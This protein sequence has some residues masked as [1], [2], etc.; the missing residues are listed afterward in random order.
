MADIET[1]DV[2]SDFIS[3][4]YT[5]IL[6]SS[7]SKENP[8]QYLETRLASLETYWN[9]F[10]KNH[11]E[12]AVNEDYYTTPY[13]KE[14]HFE[15]V[16]E[17]YTATKPAILQEIE[18]LRPSASKAYSSGEKNNYSTIGLDKRTEDNIVPDTPFKHLPAL[19][20]SQ[21]TGKQL[22]WETFRDMFT[23][24]VHRTILSDVQKLYYLKSSLSGKAAESSKNMPVNDANYSKAWAMLMSRY[25]NKRILLATHMW[26]LLSCPP[27]AKRSVDELLRLLDATNE[28]FRAF[29]NIGRPVNEW[30]DW[31]VH[32]LVHKLDHSTREDWETVLQD[33][34]DFPTYTKLSSFI[35]SRIRALEAARPNDNPQVS[36]TPNINCRHHTFLH[37]TPPNT[38]NQN[39]STLVSTLSGSSSQINHLSD[40][41]SCQS[42]KGIFAT[43]YIKLSSYSD[44]SII[45]RGFLDS[46]SERSLITE[47]VA[48]ALKLTKVK[49][50][51]SLKGIGDS[52]L[53]S[54]NHKAD[55][56]VKSPKDPDFELPV[57]AL[58]LKS[59]VN[60]TLRHKQDHRSW[61]H[62]RDLDLADPN[63]FR[64]DDVHC[65]IGIDLLGHILLPGL[66]KGPFNSPTAL[67]TV[68]G[69]IFFGHSNPSTNHEEKQSFSILH[70]EERDIIND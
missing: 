58:V 21:F 68:F 70:V 57:Q 41:S 25:D 44:R 23:A 60:L 42:Q 48:Q 24:M 35:E 65:V 54:S 5:N 43:A 13:I 31:F 63:Y 18:I 49:F 37:D 40:A 16:E 59:L 39:V 30:D 52:S 7:R 3:T 62:L 22:E 50:N 19:S 47:R 32:I 6:K 4:F 17:E 12:I 36:K 56:I 1:E 34:E 51:A 67:R 26:K 15:A 64:P 61:S 27:A 9:N 10:Y 29:E 11:L 28:S 55:L 53:G 20:L 8:L 66:K 2:I 45:I 38:P 33:T 69:W 14:N 46:G